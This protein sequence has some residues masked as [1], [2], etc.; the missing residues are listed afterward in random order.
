MTKPELPAQINFKG[1]NF[2]HLVITK[3]L[4]IIGYFSKSFSLPTEF[5]QKTNITQFN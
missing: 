5:P 3:M 4:I 2:M 1:Y